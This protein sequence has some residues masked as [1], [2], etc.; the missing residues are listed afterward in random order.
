MRTS[1]TLSLVFFLIIMSF[2]GMGWAGSEYS[3]KCGNPKCGYSSKVLFGG[4]MGFG[5]ITGYCTNCGDFVHITWK[6]RERTPEGFSKEMNQGPT[7]VAEV[8]NFQTPNLI[9]LYSCPKCSKPFIKIDH[10]EG[11]KYC[12][13]CRQPS[14]SVKRTGLMYD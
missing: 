2:S 4:G 7:P 9:S 5:K 8:W 3:L 6:S 12:P 13:K 1:Y 11:L 10:I 14:L